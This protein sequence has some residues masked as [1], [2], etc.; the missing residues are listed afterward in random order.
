MDIS[1]S[2]LKV[3]GGGGGENSQRKNWEKRKFYFHAETVA[4]PHCWDSV[5][6][7]AISYL[8]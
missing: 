4:K 8:K 3:G 7:Q 1:E 5:S 6:V 2:L